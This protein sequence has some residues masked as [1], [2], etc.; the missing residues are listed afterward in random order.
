M[1]VC[2]QR[3]SRYYR[4]SG[5]KN[6]RMDGIYQTYRDYK[7]QAPEKTKKVSVQIIGGIALGIVLIVIILFAIVPIRKSGLRKDIANLKAELQTL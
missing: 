3:S 5:L 6:K 1:R 2:V 7:A 4:A